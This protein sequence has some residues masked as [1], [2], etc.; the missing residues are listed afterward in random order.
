LEEFLINNYS[1]LTKTFIFVTVCVGIFF[2]KKYKCTAVTF[3][4]KIIIYLFFVEIIGSYAF[5]YDR[6]DFLK[7]IYN[8][9]FRK[10]Y[11]WYTIT[12]DLVGIIL[13]SV[14]YQKIINKS[15][16]KKTVKYSTYIF[17]VFSILYI[18]LNSDIL[19]QHFF[20]VIQIL[21]A[22]II[23]MCTVFYFMELLLNDK[24]INFYKSIYFYISIGVFL[25]WI[26]LTP[27]SFYDLYFI[28]ADWNFIFLQWQ[29]YL[30]ANFFM[31]I[32]FTIG[33]IVSK[34]E[35]SK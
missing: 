34:P 19:F 27:L 2:Y 31:Y 33:L 4:I 32:T 5:F 7:P 24:I 1:L 22:I 18:V 14:F 12:F 21:G 20:P 29:I 25:W 35:V 16:F 13:F 3:F 28:N 10:T 11:W 6:F 17:T 15:I 26:I 30:F 23:L 9:I 8:S